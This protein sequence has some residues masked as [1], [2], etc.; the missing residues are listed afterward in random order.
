MPSSSVVQ[1]RTQAEYVD[2][3][4]CCW[5]G[6][7]PFVSRCGTF[8]SDGAPIWVNL[9]YLDDSMQP[10]QSL[11][12]SKTSRKTPARRLTKRHVNHRASSEVDI[13]PETPSA[14]CDHLN[15]L[16]FAVRGRLQNPKGMPCPRLR[17]HG[18]IYGTFACFD[19]QSF[20][21]LGSRGEPGL[22]CN[23]LYGNE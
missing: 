14:A 15:M 11:R 13:P 8:C 4:A 18:A 5:H 16:K 3:C 19:G 23:P 17:R 6:T 7:S 9:G 2:V 22:D 10:G 1:L 21:I 12:H 20:A